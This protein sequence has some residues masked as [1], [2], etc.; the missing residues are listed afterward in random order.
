MGTESQFV[1][2]KS[3]RAVTQANPDWKGLAKE[4]VA[5][6]NARGGEVHIGI[7]NGEHLPPKDQTIHNNLANKVHTQIIDSTYNVELI[8]DVE[9]AKN[10]GQYIRLKV[11]RSRAVASTSGGRYYYRVGEESR[12]LVG[13]EVVRLATDRADWPW[14]TLTTAQVP[15]S[16]ADESKLKYFISK[17]KSSEN[18]KDS[19]KKKT[20]RH[21]LD[22]FVL[23]DGKYLTNL[24]ILCVGR[25]SDRAKLGVAPIIHFIKK[26]EAGIKTFKHV[27]DD[28]A[29]S[30]ME[31]VDAV[32]EDIPD[33]REGYEVPNGMRRDLVPTYERE[34]V[35]ELLVNA[36][37]HRPYTQK[38]DI[39]INLFPDRLELVNPGCLPIGITPQ[40]ILHKSV[41]RNDHL[42]R[43][44]HDT[45]LMEREGTGMN[46]MYDILLSQ[47][48][49][50]PD[51]KEGDDSFSVT[52]H[53]RAP[54]KK[55]IDLIANA[56]KF[57]DLYPDE[58]IVLGMLAKNGPATAQDMAEKLGMKSVA[59]IKEWMKRLLEKGIVASTGKTRATRYSIAFDILPTGD[60]NEGSPTP[61]VVHQDD[62]M[63]LVE[64][65]ISK[66]PRSSIGEILDRL[67]GR[68]TRNE[69]RHVLS[70]LVKSGRIVSEG[71]K[72]GTRYMIP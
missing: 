16:A 49:P 72:R 24:G 52:V 26:D 42:A 46:R 20:P 51:L 28:H 9:T 15:R 36:L 66:N 47:G 58:R 40:N 61:T 50:A 27:W 41:R 10:G 53:R 19:V 37:V 6:A 2:R 29:L 45:G 70:N 68:I 39:Y 14:E 43:L 71:I 4:C 67:G 22:H 34:I 56:S 17:L 57:L 3:L 60:S 18:A 1:E 8:S 13:N 55:V 62:Y 35:R 38:G 33:F 59:E 65:D 12:P 23:A 30:P 44:F 54:N 7:E 48:R 63:T 32:W 25:R 64:S 11:P 5:F 31:L 21:I 69:L